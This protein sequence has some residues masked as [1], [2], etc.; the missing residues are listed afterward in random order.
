[1]KKIAEL[2]MNYNLGNL[3]D[4]PKFVTGGKTNEFLSAYKNNR[5]GITKAV[6][7]DTLWN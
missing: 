7:K 3:I 1:M 5:L 4:E 2:C 6:G